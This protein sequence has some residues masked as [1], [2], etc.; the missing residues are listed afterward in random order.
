MNLKHSLFTLATALCLGWLTVGCQEELDNEPQPVTEGSATAKKN[1]FTNARV[2]DSTQVYDLSITISEFAG[3]EFINKGVLEKGEMINELNGVLTL[4]LADSITTEEATF[5][6]GFTGTYAVIFTG[7]YVFTDA[8]GQSFEREA[9]ALARILFSGSPLNPQSVRVRIPD[10]PDA[11]DVILQVSRPASE[12]ADRDI[13]SNL[14]GDF[15]DSGGEFDFGPNGEEL[16]LSYTADYREPDT[17]LACGTPFVTTPNAIETEV[18]IRPGDRFAIPQAAQQTPG[19][20]RV[21]YRLRTNTGSGGQSGSGTSSVFVGSVTENDFSLAYQPP[22]TPDLRFN[23]F[24]SAYL[25]DDAGELLRVVEESETL[26]VKENEVI[27]LGRFDSLL[28]RPTGIRAQIVDKDGLIRQYEKAT[29]FEEEEKEQLA[30]V[31]GSIS[32]TYTAECTDTFDA[33]LSA[34]NIEGGNGAIGVSVNGGPEQRVEFE[35]FGQDGLL[36]PEQVATTAAIELSLQQG[37][38]TIVITSL[39]DGITDIFGFDIARAPQD[40]L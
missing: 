28:Q 37:E 34:G 10:L 30:P 23:N 25:Y 4:T 19:L 35:E 8:N 9:R 39:E 31:G 29:N 7:N 14:G 16:V 21:E 18:V 15:S 32:F 40:I 36:R 20:A 17:P 2:I 24:I 38:N 12:N 6:N 33:V 27:P 11:G 26:L 22:V 5:P 3:D 13:V 1:H